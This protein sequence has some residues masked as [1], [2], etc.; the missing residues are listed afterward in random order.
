MSEPEQN[1]T[2]FERH[3]FAIRRLHSLTG[4]VPLG[5]YM[6]VHLATNA[7]LM[8]GVETFQRAVFGIHSLGALLPMVEWVLILLPLLFHGLLGV[9]IVRTG[10]RNTRHYTYANNHRYAWQRWTGLIA[11]VFLL[12]HVLH[13]HGWFHFEPWLAL[14]GRLGMGGFRPYNAAS[15]LMMQMDGYVWPAFYL[16]GVL[17]C[18]FHLANG[19]WTAGI[20]W[21]LW[22]S[23]QA[24]ERA[25][26]VCT[27]FGVLLG[28]VGVTAWWAAVAPGP[29]DV[30]R[31]RAIEDEMFEAGLPLGLVYDRPE[32]RS[33]PAAEIEGGD[34]KHETGDP[35][36]DGEPDSSAEP[37]STVEPDSTAETDSA[38]GSGLGED[39]A[40]SGDASPADTVHSLGSASPSRRSP[41]D[42]PS[43]AS[44]GHTFAS[45]GRAVADGRPASSDGE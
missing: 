31:A 30:A 33:P 9:W 32:K 26:K 6:V 45:P 27:A 38:D 1:L 41:A 43:L 34:A 5:A 24:Q 28:V 20:T 2:F 42:G 18:V 14:I 35:D 36:S 29:E 12:T 7:S 21:G 4:I 10:K 8:N 37:D 16:V 44:P 13:L 17:A 40:A 22:I 19:L 11:L 39:T 15:T 25:T 23:P 3:E